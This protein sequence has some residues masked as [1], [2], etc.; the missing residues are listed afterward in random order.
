MYAI[1]LDKITINVGPSSM[2]MVKF[3]GESPLITND[4]LWKLTW[5]DGKSPNF[6]IGDT[7]THE[8]YTFMTGQPTPPGHV[9]PPEI[10]PY[11]QGVLTVGFP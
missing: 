8:L 3:P 7:S 4:C 9:P 2:V 1:T 5:V 6:L 10:R 11:N